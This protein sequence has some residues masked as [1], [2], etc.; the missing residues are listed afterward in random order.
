M[1]DDADPETSLRQKDSWLMLRLAER[2]N[3]TAVAPSVRKRDCRYVATNV[4]SFPYRLSCS[5][6]THHGRLATPTSDLQHFVHAASSCLPG[7]AVIVADQAVHC[8]HILSG[9]DYNRK[10]TELPS[11]ISWAG[12]MRFAQKPGW[13]YL[14]RR[15]NQHAANARQLL[16]HSTLTLHCD[17]AL[18]WE[19]NRI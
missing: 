7:S 16:R 1:H 4:N 3:C 15:N 12:K 18:L 5:L 11:C 8:K 6:C 17:R 19:L 9:Y 13:G 14:Y 2:Q 10:F